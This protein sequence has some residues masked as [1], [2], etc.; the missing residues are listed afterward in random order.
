MKLTEYTS[1]NLNVPYVVVEDKNGNKRFL[2]SN[3]VL[4]SKAEYVREKEKDPDWLNKEFL[5]RK[6]GDLLYDYRYAKSTGA[7]RRKRKVVGN[8]K[9]VITEVVEQ[10]VETKKVGRMSSSI[11]VICFALSA[12]S[13]GSMYISTVHTATYL[14]DYV[15]PSLAWLMSGVITAYTST[16]FEVSILFREQAKRFLAFIFMTLWSFVLIFSMITTVSVF[17]DSYNFNKL[18]TVTV[19]NANESSGLVLSLLQKEEQAINTSIAVLDKDIAKRQEL[20]W[21]TSVQ[22][23]DRSNQSAELKRNLEEQKKILFATPEASKKD[24]EVQKKESLF[25][26][27]GRIFHIDGG[28]IAFIMSTLPA[29]F[30]NVIAPLSLTVVVSFTTNLNKKEE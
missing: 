12:T 24:E 11:A 4:F 1:K 21:G 20:D 17:W 8:E 13:I 5:R 30:I 14:L 27:L 19:N 26:F 23:K 28:I 6:K 16:A 7:L 2:C 18:E 22:L 25:D 29:I 3:G 15:T 10:K 9:Q